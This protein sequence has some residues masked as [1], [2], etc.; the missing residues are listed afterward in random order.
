MFGSC[1]EALPDVRE[2]S[3]DLSGCLAIV[4][5]PSRMSEIGREALRNLREW[6]GG[7]TGCPGEVWRPSQ[8]TG[9]GQ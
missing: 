7:P 2:W 5:K 9:S 6:L 4:G 1:R 8:M 3:G